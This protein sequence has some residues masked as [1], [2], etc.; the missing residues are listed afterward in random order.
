MNARFACDYC[1]WLVPETCLCSRCEERFVCHRCSVNGHHA[2]CSGGF[3]IIE[4]NELDSIVSHPMKQFISAT[5]GNLNLQDQIV[6]TIACDTAG[7]FDTSTV[8]IGFVSQEDVKKTSNAE[9]LLRSKKLNDENMVTVLVICKDQEGD[10]VLQQYMSFI[11]D[12]CRM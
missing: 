7:K 4:R 8:N 10:V 12:R 2:T 6:A 1:G 11:A 5:T 9:L 3:T